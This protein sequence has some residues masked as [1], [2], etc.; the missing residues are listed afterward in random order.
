MIV[1]TDLRDRPL[2]AAFAGIDGRVTSGGATW[3]WLGGIEYRDVVLW[4]RAR[5]PVMAVRRMVIDRGLAALAF[6]PASLGTVRLV[7]AAAVVEVRRGGSNIEDILAPWLAAC[8]RLPSVSPIRFE[9]EVVDSAIELVDL[10][11]RD[12]WRLIELL[13]A[14]TVRPDA[15]LAGWTLSG[16]VVHA[17]EPSADRAVT[18]DRLMPPAP[19]ATR[20]GPAAVGGQGG[21][22]RTTIAAGANATLARDGGLSLSSIDPSRASTPRMLAVA[23]NRVPLGVSSVLATRF[24]A[25]HVLDG[26]ADV[27][28]DMSLPPAPGAAAEIVGRILVSQL[29][30]CRA[31][32]LAEVVTLE[33]CEMPLDVSLDGTKLTVRTFKATSP[34]FKAEA[35]GR[36]RL[37]EGGSW[38]W[39]ESLIS[40][41]FA[42]AADIDL[43]MAARSI[44]GGL[45]VRP[46][47]RVTAGQ[48]QLSAAAHADGGDR[49]LEVRASSRDLA[50]VQSVVAPGNGAAAAA[51]GDRLL[52]WDEPFNAWLRGRRGPGRDDRFR[53]E[54]ARI[55]SPALEVS[56]AG[57]A[58]AATAH[59]TL[60]IEKL[61]ASAAEVL[62]LRDLAVAGT[63]RGRI[64][65]TRVPATGVATAR[66]LASVTDFERIVAGRPE[67]RDK[68]ITLEAEGCGSMA[69]GAVLVDRAHA[70]LTAADDRLEMTLTGGALVDCLAGVGFMTHGAA[71][72]PWVRAGPASEG[73]SA[74]CS[75]AGDLGRWQARYEGL[76]NAVDPGDLALAGSV[77]LAAALA[78]RGDTWQISRCGGEI[79]KFMATFAGRRIS[80]PRVVLT[81]AGL[82]SP[83]DG[84]LEISSAEM[85]T[86]SLSLR[87][88]GLAVLP[89]ASGRAGGAAGPVDR[90]RGRIQWQADV[91]RIEPWIIPAG[92]SARWPAAGRVW[93]T[94][95]M[96]DTPVGTNMLVEAT[97]SQ[98]SLASAAERAAP[99]DAA[100]RQVWAE[101]RATLLFEMTRGGP[102]GA[103]RISVDRLALQSSTVA[104][105]ARGSIGEWS[106]R[107]LLELDGTLSYDWDLLSRLLTP[108]TGGRLR[109][110]GGGPRPFVL[111]G[112]LV[113][114]GAEGV[115]AADGPAP[116]LPADWLIASGGP[117]TGAV[118]GPPSR[119][120]V[121][122][123]TS[124]DASSRAGGDAAGWLRSV[125]IDTSTA[126]SAA[127]IEGFAVEAGE[128]AVR[129]FEGQLALGP[130][131]IGASGGRL[132][133]APWVRLLPLPGELIVPP[134]RIVDRVALSS[135]V[136]DGW[137]SWVVPLVGHSTKTEGIASVDLAGARLPLSDPFAGELSG[138]ILFEN[139][140]VTPGARSQPLV[141]L[142][143]KLQSVIDPRFAF[144]DKAVILRVRP[145]PVRVKLAD[146]RVWHE[147][148][149][150]DMG[151][152]VVRTA[153]SVGA[154][155]T[156]AMTTEVAFRGDIAGAT[157]VIGQLLRT[158]LTIPLRG[159]VS[160]PQ[161]DAAAIDGILGRIVENTAEAVINDGLN[162]GLEA[163]FGNPPPAQSPPAQP[164]R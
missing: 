11:R 148:L 7:G 21:L 150:M 157:P 142:I 153:G 75:I 116:P 163:I 13:A 5:R 151:Q 97:G 125:S 96:L 29:A 58:E 115:A 145:E 138:Q 36:I 27:R 48:L 23:A 147:G 28:L 122:V 121:P 91:G 70:V 158:P 73:I 126:W 22:D 162:R 64:D 129:L 94:V 105:E 20:E 16:R 33:R 12:A 161:F 47:V 127:E 144:G 78:A 137:V 62:D 76:P 82:L 131:D 164:P 143:V 130:F 120:A 55:G 99:G 26:L 59:W 44:P 38:E 31:D 155:G 83:A 15:P 3:N 95:E 133:G 42:L 98:L 103:D 152:L 52:R 61:V 89:V 100:A 10:D 88:G 34:L 81:A 87:T 56:A 45:R 74:D 6:D 84:R 14:G 109:L 66:L 134:G 17:G 160:R 124:R 79:E 43:T 93:G 86:T 24:D 159:T 30:V 72:T 154:D 68:E 32:T 140:E 41:D 136:C 40:E 53:V 77:E 9:V 156:L 18:L 37:P 1:L 39:A 128:M 35:S 90:L 141:N 49:L 92:E 112:P 104:V 139:L 85:L 67:W 4:D 118:P 110:A 106:S 119:A 54:E 60:D 8:G 71:A 123:A 69:G 135:R 50:A 65:L 114:V 132:R 149:V 63:S 113:D 57:S 102:P 111:R 46:D 146:R 25:T 80:E 108:W 51:P 101:P 107:R 2:E 117:A 19:A